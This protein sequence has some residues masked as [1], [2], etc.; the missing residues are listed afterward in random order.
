MSE[1]AVRLDDLIHHVRAQEPDG[2]P[3]AQLSAAVL[4]GEHLGEAADHL[5][6]HFVDQARRTGA[7]WTDIGR[8][9][10]VTKQAA[11]KRFVAGGLPEPTDKASWN[12]FTDRGRSAVSEAASIA[13]LAGHDVTSVHVL[14]GLVA[15]PD[16]LASTAL[17]R[18][19]A[20]ADA[21]REAAYAV[22][23]PPGNPRTGG[24]IPSSPDARKVWDLTLREALRLGHNYVGTEHILLALLAEEVQASSVLAGLGVTQART[25][26]LIRATLEQ[27]R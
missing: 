19:H 11:Q 15:D 4:V 2:D 26:E 14:L 22:L 16:S 20:T 27:M 9:M 12:R 1:P 25:E 7:S 8:S 18:Q 10:G 5:I 17:A 13:G 21:V 6:G 3:L 23:D 24:H